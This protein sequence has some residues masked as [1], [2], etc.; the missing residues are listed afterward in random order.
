MRLIDY[1]AA[2]NTIVCS[3]KFQHLNILKT[4][5]MFRDQSTFNQINQIGIDRRHVPSVLDVR[6][7]RSGRLGQLPCRSQV[8]SKVCVL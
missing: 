5:W 1:V 8:S 2:I 6:T 7:F 3:T 4:T